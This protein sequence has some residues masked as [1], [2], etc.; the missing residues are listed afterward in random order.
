MQK[1]GEF[2]T[3]RGFIGGYIAA[4]V[5]VAAVMGS[6]M[7]TQLQVTKTQQS[8]TQRAAQ[9]AQLTQ[10]INQIARTGQL[11]QS[12]SFMA[13]PPVKN[14][15]FI[16]P[17][18]GSPPPNLGIMNDGRN[19]K[20]CV[21]DNGNLPARE[22][23]ADEIVPQSIN[24][25]LTYWEI[26][27]A[28]VVAVIMG[29]R[30]GVELRCNDL[31][32]TE[33]NV[34]L[35]KNSQEIAATAAAM[36]S[37]D[38]VQLRTN[39][40]MIDTK[41]EG[42][43]NLLRGAVNCN[44][45]TD[46]LLYRTND[47]GGTDFYCVPEQDPALNA[48]NLGT[49]VGVFAGKD[50]VGDEVNA[51]NVVSR[52]KFRSLTGGNG[53]NV[54]TEGDVIRVAMN[55]SSLSAGGPGVPLVNAN[56]Q[57]VRLIPGSN[58]TVTPTSDG[59][60]V[61]LSA[62]IPNVPGG[63][64][65]GAVN[66]G[67]GPGQ[68]FQGVN[69]S[70]LVFRS[71]RS[72]D[73]SLEIATVG[74]E[75]VFTNRAAVSATGGLNVG[76]VADS[77]NTAN[78]TTTIRSVFLGKAADN[79]LLFRRVQSGAGIVITEGDADPAN[80]TGPKTLRISSDVVA[81]GG[82][83]GLQ[84]VGTGPGQIV[85]QGSVGGII[86]VRTL[87]AGNGVTITTQGDNVIISA[88]ATGGLQPPAQACTANQK[89]IYTVTGGVG[90]LQ[91]VDETDPR[92]L[93]LLPV[94]GACAAN[95]VLSFDGTRLICVAGGG[96]G[97][98]NGAGP[99]IFYSCAVNFQSAPVAE[100]TEGNPCFEARKYGINGGPAGRYRPLSCELQSNNQYTGSL[101]WRSFSG[102]GYPNGG[103][104]AAN[105]SSGQWGGSNGQFADN[106]V[107]NVIV[108]DTQAR[109]NI[110][111]NQVSV[112]NCSANQVLGVQNGQLICQA[113]PGTT[114]RSFN[115]ARI[116]AG[117]APDANLDMAFDIWY[118]ADRTNYNAYLAAMG[119][120]ARQFT[121]TARVNIPA[122][123]RFANIASQCVLTGGEGV[124]QSSSVEVVFRDAANNVVFTST[125]CAYTI[126]TGGSSGGITGGGGAVYGQNKFQNDLLPIPANAASVELVGLISRPGNSGATVGAAYVRGQATF[127]N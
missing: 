46:K 4:G 93:T 13:P 118:I 61:I 124:H 104:A 87:S 108:V 31:I 82:I 78:D 103:T 84:N 127:L 36:G 37:N 2:Q 38:S 60:G 21:W 90:S 114:D 112:P 28:P 18:A 125:V 102:G 70:S 27:S 81:G 55:L 39:A 119:S 74:N 29:N 1:S 5:A 105:N 95:Q 98:G 88:N 65:N 91:C 107:R 109:A 67:A 54:T 43:V 57:I 85:R 40:E 49:G 94:G 66:L 33:G 44:P 75:I 92:V 83:T 72:A 63:T 16:D 120:S 116:N 11:A 77:G 64:I 122:N 41:G 17:G 89:L 53:I 15:Q 47:V 73:G 121:R 51:A 50:F 126:Y 99:A 34:T 19:V 42:A 22:L 24:Q 23:A 12:N 117:N 68:V 76:G 9:S 7:M 14:P 56:G 30:N 59:N 101:F 115:A 45:L 86:S 6:L 97:N 48:Q 62:T 35:A 25:G 26:K 113:T 10:A 69:G 58:L 100:N 52:L 96:T 111:P 80:P 71:L 20:Y 32:K 110:L 8:V 106:C 79:S 3:Q 123:A